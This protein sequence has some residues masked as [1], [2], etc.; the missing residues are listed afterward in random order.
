M[1]LQISSL[2]NIQTRGEILDFPFSNSPH[3]TDEPFLL[4]LPFLDG[5]IKPV[6]SSFQIRT[7]KIAFPTRLKV[8]PQKYSEIIMNGKAC[9]LCNIELSDR[10][11]TKEGVWATS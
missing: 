4:P 11:W 10:H 3:S 9:L 1:E 6:H 2:S 8:S 7:K 5:G